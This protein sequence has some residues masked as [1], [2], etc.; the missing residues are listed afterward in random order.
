MTTPPRCFYC[1]NVEGIDGRPAVPHT[2]PDD[3][4]VRAFHANPDNLNEWWCGDLPTSWADCGGCSGAFPLHDL[5]RSGGGMAAEPTYWCRRCV[6]PQH[7]VSGYYERTTCT[8]EACTDKAWKAFAPSPRQ[9][10]SDAR[11]AARS[12]TTTRDAT[13]PSV[14]RKGRLSMLLAERPMTTAEA[15]REMGVSQKTVQ[16]YLDEVGAVSTRDGRSV[17]WS[18]PSEDA[19]E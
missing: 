13:D 14:E 15:A 9:R 11:S 17:T 8:C 1:G 7:L 3:P 12:A 16:R 10:R 19:S 6:N 4:R 18:M 2:E 5:V